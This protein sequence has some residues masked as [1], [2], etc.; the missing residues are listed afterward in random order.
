MQD[1]T[2]GTPISSLKKNIIDPGISRLINN[3]NDSIIEHDDKYQKENDQNDDYE[4]DRI[5]KKKTN[6]MRNMKKKKPREEPRLQDDYV[7]E[8]EEESPTKQTSKGIIGSLPPFIKEIIILTIL[9]YIL[10]M[11]IVKKSI[12]DYITYINPDQDGNVS[13]IGI[14]I[15]GLLLATIFI[16]V[17][18]LALK[19]Y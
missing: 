13:F 12:G 9:Y 14:I 10:S 17:R 15:Y 19:Y 2:G 5:N 11:G 6:K 7:E 1:Y 8:F 3:V 18:S 4:E 16:V